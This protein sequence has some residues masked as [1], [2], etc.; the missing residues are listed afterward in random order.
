MSVS[1]LTKKLLNQ[2]FGLSIRDSQVSLLLSAA[3]LGKMICLLV[4]CEPTESRVS[5]DSDLVIGHR[6]GIVCL[7]PAVPW[8]IVG[9]GQQTCSM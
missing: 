3:R 8:V 6:E 2:R 1:T 7:S 4:S 5:L 9:F